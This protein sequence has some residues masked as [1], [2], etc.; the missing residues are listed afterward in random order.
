[1]A[2]TTKR[3]VS[4]EAAAAQPATSRRGPSLNRVTLIGRLTR[5][6]EL[7]FTP[8]GVPVTRF[9][10]VNNG[11]DGP[12]FNTIVA[13]RRLAEVSAEY[14]AKGRLV[15]VGGRLKGRRWVAADGTGRYTVDIIADEIQFL[16]PRP[17]V[18]GAAA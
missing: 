14:L 10:L 2:T 4:T 18:I 15:Y 8:D 3:T 1:M 9:T 17:A 12:M 11:T 16:S 6:P 5:D 13:W 7:R